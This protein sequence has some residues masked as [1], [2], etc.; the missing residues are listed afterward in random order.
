MLHAFIDESGQRGHTDSASS[1]FLMSAIVV[2]DKNLPHLHDSLAALRVSLKRPE[3]SY[4]SWKNMRSHS[5]R[6]HIAATIGAQ[7]WLRTITVVACKRHLSPGE[8]TVDHM[9]MYQFRLLLERLSWLARQH[10][11]VVTYT[12][13]H[14]KRFQIATLREYE[15]N[16]RALPTEIAW[17]NLD[18]KGGAIDQPQRDERLQFADLV[19]SAQAT[20]FNPDRFGNTERRYLEAT[21]P[22][23]YRHALTSPLTSYGLKMH[24]WNQATKAAYPWVAT[25]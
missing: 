12:L 24:P 18:P 19:V 10:D 16:L 5:E 20:A 1:H 23:I 14:I 13:A 7:S 11:D 6:L 2:R 15:S 25:L 4:L 9:Y 8:M 17:K 22:A 3:D 21:V